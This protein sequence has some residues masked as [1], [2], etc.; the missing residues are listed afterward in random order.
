M[1]VQMSVRTIQSDREI[2][3]DAQEMTETYYN[4]LVNTLVSGSLTEIHGP[5]EGNVVVMRG[6]AAKDS[7]I[8][9]KIVSK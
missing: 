1:K 8:T 2:R 6:S 3:F 5:V 4:D 7:I 9:F